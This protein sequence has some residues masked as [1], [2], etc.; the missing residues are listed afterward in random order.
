MASSGTHISLACTRASESRLTLTLNPLFPHLSHSSANCR[1]EL[2]TTIRLRKPIVLVCEV[3]PEKGGQSIGEYMEECRLACIDEK[4]PSY[5]EYT[6]PEEVIK[7]LFVQDPIIWVRA[8]GFQLESL[9][10]IGLRMLRCLPYYKVRPQQL[11][12]GVKVAGQVKPHV[13]DSTVRLLVCEANEGAEQAA[14]AIV[15]A[16]KATPGRAGIVLASAEEALPLSDGAPPLEKTAFLLYLNKRT[17]LNGSDD[18]CQLVQQALDADVPVVMLHEQDPAR[19]GGVIRDVILQT[20]EVLR[21]PPYQLYNTLAIP[22]FHTAEHQNVSLWK[23]L[24]AI[25]NAAGPSAGSFV[26]LSIPQFAKTFSRLSIS[27]R[28]PS[29]KKVQ[30]AAETGDATRVMPDESSR[31]E[32]EAANV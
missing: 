15:A 28:S 1:R 2:Y 27:P 32:P 26:K 3:D 13:L 18:L 4:P 6:G 29:R 16:A 30:L 10:M 7:A 23:A 22:L 9:K 25:G 24:S 21:L 5:P 31:Q 17:F 14:A 20:P 11:A 12:K 19:G 8:S